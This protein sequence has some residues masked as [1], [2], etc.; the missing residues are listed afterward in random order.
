MIKIMLLVSRRPDVSREEFRRY[1]EEHHA[2]LAATRLPFLVRYVR[3]YVVDE[4][5]ADIDCDCVTEFWFDHPG[6]WREAARRD[7]P[8]GLAG[9]LRGG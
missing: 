4:F 6:P 7:S 8:R 9:P 3:N 5:R 1:Y 2:P